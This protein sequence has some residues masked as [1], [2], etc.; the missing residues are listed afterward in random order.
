MAPPLTCFY[1]EFFFNFGLFFKKF[2]NNLYL[3]IAKFFA[4]LKLTN[5]C[6]LLVKHGFST[7]KRH[8]HGRATLDS[9]KFFSGPKFSEEIKKNCP[10]MNICVSRVLNFKSHLN[11]T[12]GGPFESSWAL[13]NGKNNKKLRS[14]RRLGAIR[15]KFKKS[16]ENGKMRLNRKLMG[17]KRREIFLKKFPKINI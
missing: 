9:S 17:S 11:H 3:F 12:I 13:E 5:A 7:Q 4:S 6:L 1:R 14:K 10:K 16:P 2:Y 15:L 8:R